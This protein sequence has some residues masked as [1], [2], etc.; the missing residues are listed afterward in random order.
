MK[1]DG[2][3][4]VITGA[5]GGIGTALA[6]RFAAEGAAGIVL[7]DLDLDAVRALA[8]DLA[9]DAVG[10]R[11]DV[12]VED[13]VRALVETALERYGRVDVFC[14]NAGITSG[15]GIEGDDAVWQ[16]SWEVNVRAHLYA[17]RAVLPSMLERGEGYLLQTCSAAGLLTAVGD[18]PY[19]VTKHAAVGFAEWLSITYGNRGI[20][21]SALCPQGV[22]TPM[23]R[24]GLDAGHVGAK[25]T[26]ASGAVLSPDDVADAV[27]AGLAE[28]RF[29]IL[30][31][32][33]VGTYLA[34]KTQDPDRWLAGMRRM[35]AGFT[36]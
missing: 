23:L 14:S 5:A 19:S 34:H 17:A 27:V 20:R 18:A 13:D 15:A 33:E 31:H 22:D 10:V 9:V 8:A 25:V 3:V 6:R 21:V 28:E 30:P 35:A 26:A 16:R 2:R 7:S 24:D 1:L 29:L 11:T 4:V 12:T 32:A 36:E